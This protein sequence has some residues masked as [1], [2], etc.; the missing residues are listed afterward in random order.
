MNK[1]YELTDKNIEND[2]HAPCEEDSSSPDCG[3][4]DLNCLK[5]R[6]DCIAHAAQKKLLEYMAENLMILHIDKPPYCTSCQLLK[7]FGIGE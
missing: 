6:D 4:K 7:E 5:C 1:P 3:R 2:M